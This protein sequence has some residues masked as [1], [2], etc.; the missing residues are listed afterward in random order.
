MDTLQ[1]QLEKTYEKFIGKRRSYEEE[2]KKNYVLE[3]RVV[4]LEMEVAS[5]KKNVRTV[6][7]VHDI[8][9]QIES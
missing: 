5:L 1:V 2:M 8:E 7:E 3:Q 4:K 9:M 6:I